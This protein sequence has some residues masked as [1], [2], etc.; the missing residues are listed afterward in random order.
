[1][2]KSAEPRHTSIKVRSFRPQVLLTDVI[3]PDGN[4]L[5]LIPE[6]LAAN[7]T[8]HRPSVKSGP[9]VSLLVAV[10]ISFTLRFMINLLAF[11]VV[12]IRGFQNLYFVSVSLLSGFLIPVHFFPPRLQ[13]IAY[14]SPAPS[15]LQLPVDV[16][17]GRVIGAEALA[18][19]GVQ[20]GWL[21][22]LV[23]LARVMQWAAARRLVVQGG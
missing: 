9:M 1:M 21:V 7:P 5:D 12:D 14:A 3:L 22:V 11:W 8:T 10:S 2:V 15:I 20:L 16:M 6:L 18:T 13:Q 4:G 23:V 17:S 19:I